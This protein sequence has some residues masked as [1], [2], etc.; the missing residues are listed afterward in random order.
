M[1][2]QAKREEVAKMAHYAN[3]GCSI[4]SSISIILSIIGLIISNINLVIALIIHIIAI[5]LSL[6]CVNVTSK[7]A[8]VKANIHDDEYIERVYDLL[9]K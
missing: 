9:C 1:D 3:Y 5:T 2:I 7:T 8:L 4:I 6:M